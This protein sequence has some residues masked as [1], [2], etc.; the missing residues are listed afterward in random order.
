[1]TGAY[2]TAWGHEQWD[3]LSDSDVST[4]LW[5]CTSYPLGT[6]E[7]V[8]AEFVAIRDRA[9]G[10]LVKALEQAAERVEHE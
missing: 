10:D 2:W 5:C 9:G 3:G 8:E 1:M 6:L 7:E 4:I